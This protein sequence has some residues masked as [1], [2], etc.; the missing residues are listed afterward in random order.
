MRVLERD[1]RGSETAAAARRR[2]ARLLLRLRLLRPRTEA[3]VTHD[4]IMKYLHLNLDTA[5]QDCGGVA[6]ASKRC[7][8]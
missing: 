2:G 8:L 3:L 4:Q 1:G 7:R 5:A 6:A